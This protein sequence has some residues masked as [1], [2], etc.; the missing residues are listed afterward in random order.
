MASKVRQAATDTAYRGRFA[1]SPTGRLHLGSLFTAV[2]S[3][4]RARSCGGSWIVRMEDLDPPR[5]EVGAADAILKT[6][7]AF[8][9]NADAPI[10]FQSQRHAHY[11]AALRLLE[12]AGHAF[13]CA[14]SRTE[15]APSGLHH[16][17]CQ[18]SA[19][20]TECRRL[21]VP[22]ADWQFTDRHL[23][24]YRQH[25][26]AVGDFVLWRADGL[27][28]YQLAVVVDDA[29][30]GITEVVR[31]NDLL[32]STPRQIYLQQRLALPTPHY[33]H[34]PVLIDQSGNKLSKS[35]AALAVADDNALPTLKI[36]LKWLGQPDQ[37][38]AT[39]VRQ[40]LSAASAAFDPRRL[41]QAAGIR[42]DGCAH[43]T[44]PAPPA[45]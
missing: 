12:A 30:Q 27:P 25:S 23:G 39:S 43:Y 36:L 3:Y 40:L 24:S 44:I 28:A 14:C 10:C 34:L 31:G 35:T 9:L 20:A 7:R 32:D 29:A 22:A 2:A 42:I 13:A 19:G 26:S 37:N 8:G 5:A 21:R 17:V 4:L 6:L 16:G 45:P 41:P 33:L 18:S 15:L 38:R 11:R 1:P